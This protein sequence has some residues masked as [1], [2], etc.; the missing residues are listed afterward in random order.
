M[1]LE[2]DLTF[3]RVVAEQM[4]DYVHAEVLFYP[5]G[6]IGGMK[7]PPLTIGNW[8]ETEWR[9][10]ALRETDPERIDAALE[11]ARAAVREVR[12]SA[13]DIYQLKARREFR[14]RLDTWETFLDD[15]NDD[16]EEERAYN[17]D[18]G[19]P[20][21][22]HIRFKLELLKNDVSQ[23]GAQLARLASS[24]ERLRAHFKPCKFMW[25]PELERAAP[26]EEYWWLYGAC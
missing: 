3:S 8:L 14:S 15:R 25:A 23:P 9:L 18:S 2:L 16:T 6:S 19:Y 5:I 13:S 4:D 7:I 24:D 20:T 21:Q 12:S 26:E 22:A 10:N 1:N 11:A 17:E